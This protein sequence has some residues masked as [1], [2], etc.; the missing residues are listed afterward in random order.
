MR[1]DEPGWITKAAAAALVGCDERTIERK[2][3]A[4]KI[5]GRARPG[6]PTVYLLAD[7]ENLRQAGSQEVRTGLLEPMP[8]GTRNGNGH[9]AIAPT[10]SATLEALLVDVLQAARRALP[11][12]PTGPTGPTPAP[13]GPTLFLTLAQAAAVTGLS[14]AFLRRMI[15]LGTLSAVKDRG[16]RIR[17]KDLEA[18]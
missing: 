11:D 9:G 18:L 16:W 5:S 2:H 10:R 3:R 13:T 6:F 1:I 14:Q 7:V 8:A 17:R 12:G 15:T 4:G